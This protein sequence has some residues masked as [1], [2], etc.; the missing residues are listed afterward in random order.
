[1]KNVPMSQLRSIK[2][3]EIV[4][5]SCQKIEEVAKKKMDRIFK[6]AEGEIKKMVMGYKDLVTEAVQESVKEG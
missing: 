6:Q 1:M 2:D 3:G 5:A 4:C